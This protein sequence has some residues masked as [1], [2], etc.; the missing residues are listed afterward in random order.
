MI[1]V[2]AFGALVVPVGQLLTGYASTTVWLAFSVFLISQAFA[3]TGLGM[4]VAD[5][6]VDH[7]GKSALGLVYSEAITDFLISPVTPSNTARSGG[8]VYPIFRNVASALGCEPGL[9]GGR[10]I[11]FYPCPRT[12]SACR[13]R[14]CLLLP[15][16]PMY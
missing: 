12:G 2:L 7:F 8:I 9:T 10:S 15:V 3:D 13:P 5:T 11:Y 6:L 1:T 4:R 16:H 14:P